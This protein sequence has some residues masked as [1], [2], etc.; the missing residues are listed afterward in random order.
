MSK[1]HQTDIFEKFAH[2]YAEGRFL[3]ALRLVIP[4]PDICYDWLSSKYEEMYFLANYADACVFR[5]IPTIVHANLTLQKALEANIA[6]KET[7][8]KFLAI[9]KIEYQLFTNSLCPTFPN[10]FAPSM[11]QKQHFLDGWLKIEA[12]KPLFFQLLG[13][14][15]LPLM[16]PWQQFSYK[17]RPKF[18][19]ENVSG[20]M[21]LIFLQPIEGMAYGNFLKNFQ[22][23]RLLVFETVS[24]F[25]QHLQFDDLISFLTDPE[26]YIYILSLHPTAQFAAQGIEWPSAI[27]Y[28]T[29]FLMQEGPAHAVVDLM[30]QALQQKN[31]D[32]LYWIAK[33]LMYRITAE[34]YGKSRCFAMQ[35]EKGA[36]D[37]RDS[38]ML[39]VP[40]DMVLGPLPADYVGEWLD[41]IRAKRKI[42]PPQNKPKIRIAHVI[43]N[44][45]DVAFAPS[46]VLRSFFNNFN[47]NAFELFLVVT[48]CFEEQTYE[49]PPCSY[50]SVPSKVRAKETLAEFRSQGID[51]IVIEPSLSYLGGAAQVAEIFNQYN[52]DVAVFHDDTPINKLGGCLCQVPLRVMVDHGKAPK[53]PSYDL[54]IFSSEES[55]NAQQSKM[56]K[57]G[58][59]G[60]ALPFAIDVRQK[61]EGVPT[62]KE[63]LGLPKNSFMMTTISLHLDV[64]VTDEMRLAIAQILKRC[65]QAVYAPMGEVK[66]REKFNAVFKDFGVDDRVFYLG[67][68][69]NPGQAARAANLYLNEFPFGSCL[70]M[71][72]A[73]ASGCP[74]VTMFNPQWPPQGLYGRT[75]MGKDYVVSSGKV[76]DYVNL[77]CRL[78][79]EKQL[80][81]NWS[82]HTL[83]RYEQ[84]CDAKAYMQRFELILIKELNHIKDTH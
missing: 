33:R 61:W 16:Q 69:Q 36:F 43:S 63:D 65:P 56:A 82:A 6:L 64:R 77:A 23:P 76:E 70:G 45:A 32:W 26:C 12:S 48:E 11:Q 31:A 37:W 53:H 55:L 42:R 30:T 24:H 18:F 84:L 46:R 44:L 4:H 79:T 28:K 81:R 83:E 78:I 73:M 10:I 17:I 74:I 15:E 13:G 1:K 2:A 39:Y 66:E 71:L 51:S 62:T 58:M 52:I 5:D 68:Q 59:Q 3:E 57:M 75:F 25:W 35:H 29:L 54:V 19:V 60:Y 67:H 38:N 41:Q 49:Y 21:P 8:L 47:K 7:C 50:V 80:Y 72:D 40:E 22:G 27:S 14:K 20:E 34:R 9:L